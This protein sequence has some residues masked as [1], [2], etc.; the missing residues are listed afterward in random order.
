M[1][2]LGQVPGHEKLFAQL[3]S[4]R[5]LFEEHVGEKFFSVN[6]YRFDPFDHLEGHPDVLGTAFQVDVLQMEGDPH[7]DVT[8]LFGLTVRRGKKRGTFDA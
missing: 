3:Y 4:G 7:R 5:G 2:V 8:P 6:L 1:L